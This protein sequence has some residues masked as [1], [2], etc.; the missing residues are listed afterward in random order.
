MII[1]SSAWVHL[2]AGDGTERISEED[3]GAGEGAGIS[4]GIMLRLTPAQ[5][6]EGEGDISNV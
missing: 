4:A 1:K 5:I 3:V 2:A 6:R